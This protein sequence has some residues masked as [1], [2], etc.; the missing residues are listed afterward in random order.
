MRVVRLFVGVLVL[1][2]VT[3]GG[4][5]FGVT[6]ASVKAPARDSISVFMESAN[7]DDGTTVVVT[8][9][10]GDYGDTAGKMDKNGKA[11]PDG[12]YSRLDLQRG[13]IE[14]DLTTFNAMTDTAQATIDTATCSAHTTGT[15]PVE[16]LNGTGRYK[17]ISGKVKLTQTIA[18]V[19][20][21]YTSG[22]D[23]GK[24]NEKANPAA[25]WVSVTGSGTVSF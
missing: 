2:A 9:A 19:L 8:G 24:C 13:T 4:A 12:N 7:S 22:K 17:G 3:V 15:A 18:V 25:Q 5:W 20:P 21:R 1:S 11:N 23:K 6:T 14:V 10:I 16:L